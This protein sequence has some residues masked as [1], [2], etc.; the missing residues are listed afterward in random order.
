MEEAHHQQTTAGRM[1]NQGVNVNYV[2][3]PIGALTYT[4]ASLNMP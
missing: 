2:E 4:S 1:F 3:A